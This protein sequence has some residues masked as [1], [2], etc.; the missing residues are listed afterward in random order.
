MSEE[1][2]KKSAVK[3]CPNG[4]TKLAPV[5]GPN[6]IRASIAKIRRKSGESL[7]VSFSPGNGVRIRKCFPTEEEARAFARQLLADHALI[8]LSAQG[9]Q[10]SELL[11]DSRALSFLK[12]EAAKIGLDPMTA[13]QMAITAMNIMG[14]KPFLPAVRYYRDFV[15]G[16]SPTHLSKLATDYDKELKSLG[17]K[18]NHCYKTGRYLALLSQAV[19]DVEVHTLT[20][21]QCRDVVYAC[22]TDARTRHEMGH[23]LNRFFR[24]GKEQKAFAEGTTLPLIAAKFLRFTPTA[25]LIISPSNFERLLFS[26]TQVEFILMAVLRGLLGLRANEARQIHWEDFRFEELQPIVFVSQAVAKGKHTQRKSRTVDLN[27]SA[28]AWLTPFRKPSGSLFLTKNPNGNL[29]EFAM[30]IGVTWENNFLRHAFVSYMIE[31]MHNDDYVA[32]QAGHSVRMQ[33]SV[34]RLPSLHRDAVAFF[35]ILPDWR[36]HPLFVTSPEVRDYVLRYEY[37]SP[38]TTPSALAG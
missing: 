4:K 5:K 9:K 35:G 30:R 23:C 18:A 26:A 1:Q 27:P 28:I 37:I 2:S 6:G 15:D 19:G 3:S 29:Q 14:G 22:Y 12:A 32:N 38:V 21:A 7:R 33:Q 31:I 24:F 10:V 25:P 17:C 34:Y 36:N 16:F 20:S 13:V 8:G 11:D